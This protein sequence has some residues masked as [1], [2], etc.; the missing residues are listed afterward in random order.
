MG[1]GTGTYCGGFGE[2]LLY[3]ETNVGL[4]RK[5]LIGGQSD[6]LVYLWLRTLL[7]VR[8]YT[9]QYSTINIELA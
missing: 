7:C 4:F 9:V 2:L 6:E 1:A 3:D 5:P 8:V